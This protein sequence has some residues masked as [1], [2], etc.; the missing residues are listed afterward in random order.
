MDCFSFLNWRG[1]DLESESE[2]AVVFRSLAATVKS[3]PAVDVSLEAKAVKFLKS[4]NMTQLDCGQVI[5]T[6]AME[7]LNHLILFC[8]T[9]NLLALVKA[10]LIPQLIMTLN[11]LPLSF[12]EAV[13]IRVNLT[14]IISRS[15]LPAIPNYLNELGIEDGNEQQTVYETVLKQVL[16]PSEK[17]I[18]H[19]CVNRYSIIDGSNPDAA[20]FGF[21]L[22]SLPP[23]MLAT[24]SFSFA[25]T[26][27]LLQLLG[28][29]SCR[30]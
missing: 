10:E 4:V 20:R 11:P 30:C 6:A 23:S 15:I 5:N 18:W 7:V 1:E 22:A 29:G 27:A 21:S 12:M 3:Q 19:L 9:K 16:V 14:Q 24:L 8:S 26:L 25:A 17:Y 2:K 13:D 28:N